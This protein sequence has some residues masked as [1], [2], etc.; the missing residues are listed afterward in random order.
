MLSA[1][2]MFTITTVSLLFLA[3]PA[4]PANNAEELVFSKTGAFMPLTGNTDNLHGT[5]GTPFGFW[6]W[7]AAQPSPASTP[8]T[9]QAAMVC[10]GSMY[11]YFLGVEEHVASA[12]NVTENPPGS[13][14]YTI[15]VFADDFTCTL[16]NT[17]TNPGPNNTVHVFCTFSSAFG[18]GTGSA[19][20][21][22]ATIGPLS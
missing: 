8:P 5:G 16:N 21:T 2:K 18:G 19:D 17:T 4:S 10:Q 15:K 13:G 20:A 22:N 11:F 1:V 6:I 3:M 14:L 7:C 9:Y 12:F